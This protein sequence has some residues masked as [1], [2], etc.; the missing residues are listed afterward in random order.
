MTLNLESLTDAADSMA[1]GKR[2]D[3]VRHAAHALNRAYEALHFYADSHT[4]PDKGPWGRGSDD[5]GAVA[6]KALQ[7]INS[8]TGAK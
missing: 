4:A 8:L 5:F 7:D 1:P 2:R 3:A 6:T